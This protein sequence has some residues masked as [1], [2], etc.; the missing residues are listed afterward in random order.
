MKRIYLPAY[1][2]VAVVLVAWWAL[3]QSV[4]PL[5]LLALAL[6]VAAVHVVKYTSGPGS[7]SSHHDEVEAQARS[8][9]PVPPERPGGV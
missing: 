4:V 2:V 6:V 9:F 7:V 1:A 8:G 3:S 5:V